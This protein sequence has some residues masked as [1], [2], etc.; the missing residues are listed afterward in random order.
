MFVFAE[1]EI[2]HVFLLELYWGLGCV[3]CRIFGHHF[4]FCGRFLIKILFYEVSD[5]HWPL[6]YYKLDIITK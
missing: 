4:P 5:S 3:R 1:Y 2:L 6:I